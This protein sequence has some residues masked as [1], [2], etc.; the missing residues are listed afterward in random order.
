MTN[1]QNMANSSQTITRDSAQQHDKP[2]LHL[3][4]VK[5]DNAENSTQN[6]RPKV[7][8]QE[9]TVDNENLNRKKSKICCIFH[10]QVDF[11]EGEDCQACD[12]DRDSSSSS[13]S[14]ESESDEEIRR[15]KITQ[16][17]K[18]KSLKSKPNSY[19]YQPDYTKSKHS[20]SHHNDENNPKVEGDSNEH[21]HSHF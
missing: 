1:N 15:A 14:S 7:R 19:E 20:H 16:K 9:G 10:P 11:E 6:A 12:S 18:Q 8:W 21:V 5:T 13:S 4:G 17:K 2:I 3:R